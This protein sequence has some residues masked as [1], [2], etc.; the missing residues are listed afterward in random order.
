[1]VKRIY[2]VIALIALLNLVVGAGIVAF[3]AGSGRVTR[4]HLDAVVE[5]L[6]G[7]GELEEEAE[8]ASDAPERSAGESEDEIG[9][10][11]SEKEEITRR[12]LERQI[13]QAEQRLL[14]ATRTM[15]DVRRRREEFE[16]EREAAA[17]EEIQKEE[18]QAADGFKKDVEFLESLTPKVALDR[19]L[20]RP[21]DDAARMLMVLD[22]RRGKKIIET[23]HKNPQK[24]E[25][26][27]PI[28]QRLRE[29]SP[30]SGLTQENS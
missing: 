3:L 25:S 20:L 1:M 16:R 6:R 14:L 10:V 9:S 29:L 8:P 27:V 22:T 19:L 24:W 30:A 4:G 28:L 15:M 26:M 7:Y 23:A 5:T 12:N 13:T 21:V 18:E 11:G 2:H 17:A